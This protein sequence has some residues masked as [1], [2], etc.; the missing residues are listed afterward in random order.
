MGPAKCIKLFTFGERTFCGRSVTHTF[1]NVEV[2]PHSVTCP[3]LVVEADLP[4]RQPGNR[5][6]PASDTLVWELGRCQSNLSFQHSCKAFLLKSEIRQPELINSIEIT[7][8]IDFFGTI[9][10]A[11]VK[12][13]S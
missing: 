5:I 4:Q 13:I 9:S 10:I 3:V 6:Q 8:A 7:I 2:G 12:R 1:V 11:I